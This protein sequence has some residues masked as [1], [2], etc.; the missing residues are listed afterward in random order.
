VIVGC[1]VAAGWV[2]RGI[3][4]EAT[5]GAAVRRVGAAV[6]G[7]GWLAPEQAA[8][9]SAAAPAARIGLLRFGR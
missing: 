9:T 7:V 5:E 4:D 8:A 1:E 6:D 2:D 3:V